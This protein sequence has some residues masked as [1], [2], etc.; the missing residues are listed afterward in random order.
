MDTSEELQSILR[1]LDDSLTGQIEGSLI[2]SADG[3]LVAHTLSDA[4]DAERIAAMVATTMGVSRRMAAT[5]DA[6]DLNETSISASKRLVQLYLV[7]DRGAL[8]VVAE[9]GSNIAL[10][11]IKARE[12]VGAAKKALKVAVA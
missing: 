7:G 2:A 5:L 11:N 3:F 1:E 4:E 6:G 9:S 10:I 8:A 12:Q